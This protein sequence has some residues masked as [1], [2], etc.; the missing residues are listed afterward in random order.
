[1]VSILSH[2]LKSKAASDYNFRNIGIDDYGNG[3]IN[4][5]SIDEDGI[6]REKSM[7]KFKVIVNN[8]RKPGGHVCAMKSNPLNYNQ[9][10]VASKDQPMQVWDL[11]QFGK[12][13]S[14]L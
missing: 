7:N 12:D 6:V 3:L 8:N 11:T 1:M 14:K 4:E 2:R 9:F 13:N 5:L 10:A